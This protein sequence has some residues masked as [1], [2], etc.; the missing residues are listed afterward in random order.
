M[1][2]L[3]RSYCP[4]Y[5]NIRDANRTPARR[6]NTA[7]ASKPYTSYNTAR[8]PYR[9]TPTSPPLPLLLHR[10]P[11]PNQLQAS[12]TAIPPMCP[13]AVLAAPGDK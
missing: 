2:T 13:D 9:H 4:N 12:Y 7:G 8:Y 5:R 3:F 1:N 6:Q 11:S 10:P